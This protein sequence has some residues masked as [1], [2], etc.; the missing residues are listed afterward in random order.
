MNAQGRRDADVHR[1]AQ[2][3][4]LYAAFRRLGPYSVPP[5]RH[6]GQKDE[7]GYL[8][9]EG[10]AAHGRTQIPMCAAPA[11]PCPDAIKGLV[12]SSRNAQR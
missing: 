3:A 10:T 12:R 2:G 6:A 7:E 11:S 5:R 4:T 9:A 8:A 1:E